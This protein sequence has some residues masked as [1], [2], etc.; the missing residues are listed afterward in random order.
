MES[1]ATFVCEGLGWS[2]LWRVRSIPTTSL[3]LV[4]RRDICSARVSC[5]PRPISD[6]H[7]AIASRRSARRCVLRSSPVN[8]ATDMA[9]E[10]ETDETKTEDDYTPG[11]LF[12]ILSCM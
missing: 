7:P 1:L 9:S 8:A 6:P 11:K 5:R 10:G 4:A 3:C 2:V 12:N